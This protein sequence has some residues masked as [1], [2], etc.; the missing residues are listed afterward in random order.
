MKIRIVSPSD[1]VTNETWWADYWV[2]RDLETEFEKRGYQ[3]VNADAD[4]DFCLF[5]DLKTLNRVTAQR[6][7]CWVYSHPQFVRVYK[8][9]FKQYFDHVFMLSESFLPVVQGS[10]LLLGGSSKEFTPRKGKANYDVMF[11]GNSGKPKRRELINYLCGLGKYRICLV[12]G[13]ENIEGAD[14]L[15]MYVDNEHYSEFWN[16]GLLS[17]YSAHEDM[18]AEGF[19]AVR[20][21][22]I[23]R[24]SENLCISDKNHGLADM[25]RDI[26][27]FT[28]KE[29][30][31]AQIDWFLQH[32]GERDNIAQKCREDAEQ[33]TFTRIVDEIE[34]WI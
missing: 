22:D 2:K 26:P 34:R 30:L 20:I 27:M 24:C 10:T 15:G 4:L 31:E 6:K 12:G 1:G 25:F 23:F 29:D 16:Q 32:P 19:V 3:V 11:V 5:G 33:W 14:H 7:L 8:G 17:F 13:W 18:R 9:F 28:D 21:L